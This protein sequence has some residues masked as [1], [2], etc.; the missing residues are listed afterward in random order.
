VTKKSSHDDIAE[1]MDITGIPIETLARYFD[2][3]VETV[4]SWKLRGLPNYAMPV[5]PLLRDL[6]EAGGLDKHLR[7]RGLPTKLKPRVEEVRVRQSLTD[8]FGARS[9]GEEANQTT[10]RR[11]DQERQQQLLYGRDN[12]NGASTDGTKQ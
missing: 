3:K 7:S 2:V 5:L 8:N 6:Y 12:N 4:S 9:A 11:T 1:L 10:A